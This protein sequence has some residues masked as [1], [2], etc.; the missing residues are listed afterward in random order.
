MP[1]DF[2]ASRPYRRPNPGVG[3]QRVREPHIKHLRGKLRR[4]R[5]SGAGWHRPC[6]L[7]Y[8]RRATRGDPAAFVKKTQQTPS[9]ML[10][11]A[12]RLAKEVGL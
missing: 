10:A 3:S 5:F 1:A 11:L 8:G 9:T 4:V 6:D 7:R 12:E 2:R